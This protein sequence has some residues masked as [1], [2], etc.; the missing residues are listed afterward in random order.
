MVVTRS[1]IRCVEV[2][3]FTVREYQEGLALFLCKTETD[4]SENYQRQRK[5]K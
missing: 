5:C 3:T 4:G 2:V 1:T